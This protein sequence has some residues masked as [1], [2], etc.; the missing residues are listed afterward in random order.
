MHPV[1]VAVELDDAL[2]QHTDGVAEI[3]DAVRVLQPGVRRAVRRDLGS[4]AATPDGDGHVDH[5]IRGF[6]L[7]KK[8]LVAPLLVIAQR[9]LS[10]DPG[11]ELPQVSGLDATPA[12]ARKTFP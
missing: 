7:Q 8:A 2:R 5:E 12:E 4:G 1:V 3:A 9:F 11:P 6:D 10:F